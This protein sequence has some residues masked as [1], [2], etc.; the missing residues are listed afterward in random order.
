MTAPVMLFT[1][2]RPDHT[3]EVIEALSRNHLAKD[4]EVFAY[5]CKPK[6]A[7]HQKCVSD[8][9]KILNSYRGSV[10]FKNFTVVEKKTYVP[11]GPAMVD[12]VSEVIS[13]Y[14]KI[15]VLEDDIVTSEDFLDFMNDALSFYESSTDIYM[16]SGYS[17]GMKDIKRLK[18]DVYAVHRTCPWG[19]ATWQDRWDKY[20]YD[21]RNEY[22][23]IS[24]DRNYR[25]KMLS[26]SRDLPI[27]MD[28][29]IYGES[30]MD[31]NWEQQMCY[32]QFKNNMN[33]LCPKISKVRNIGFKNGT[34]DEPIGLDEYFVP[35]GSGY[36]LEKPELNDKF[37]KKYNMKFIFGLR[38]KLMHYASETLFLLSPKIY[39]LVAKHHF[40]N[41][42]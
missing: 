37:Q 20:V 21:P 5:I 19:W 12:A 4:T 13:E 39:R 28:G 15:I 33:T 42:N 7:E 18:N 38:H 30:N 10:A 26:W 16:V 34:H 23:A 9:L 17:F 29:L 40:R 27:T 3:K 35:E 11:L 36:V 22:A 8:T 1:Y 24:L 25:R 6:N 2:S 32:C 41:K 31:M 14:G